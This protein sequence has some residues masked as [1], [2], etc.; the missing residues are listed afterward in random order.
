MANENV[1]PLILNESCLVAG[2]KNVFR[3]KFPVGSIKMKNAKIAVSNT[4]LYYSWFN[5]SAV[6]NNNQYQFVFPAGVS[7]TVN[8]PDGFYTIADLNTHLQQFCI[9]NSLYLVNPTGQFVYYLEFI[10]NSTYYAV[11]CNAY[12]VPEM[13]PSG[14]TNP[15]N[16]VFILPSAPYGFVPRLQLGTNNF[17]K[18]LGFKPSASYPPTPHLTPNIVSTISTYTPQITPVQSIIIGCSLLNNK[19]SN[20]STIL[21]SF[22]PSNST[23]GSTITCDASQYSFVDVQEGDYTFFDITFYDQSLNP[24]LMNDANIIVQLLIKTFDK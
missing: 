3:Y 16:M 22:S 4:A 1:Y 18:I 24:L 19:Y 7:Y 9:L 12:P 2:T 20:P 10:T 5:I 11:Q 23:F 15:A 8:I 13:L 17:C 14:W 21:Y 6:N